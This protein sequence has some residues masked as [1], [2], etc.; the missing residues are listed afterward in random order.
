M[1]NISR[2]HWLILL[3]FVTCG[4]FTA[5]NAAHVIG[6]LWNGSQA[7]AAHFPVR[8]A[9]R[10]FGASPYWLWQVL[11]IDGVPFTRGEQIDDAIKGRRPGDEIP[12]MLKDPK[13]EV[14]KV[15]IPVVPAIRPH[16]RT[17]DIV[18]L[19]AVSLFLNVFCFALAFVVVGIR[20]RDPLA[21]LLLAVLLSFA[22]TARE[23]GWD[24][25]FPT[26]ALIWSICVR[27][28]WPVWMMLFGLYFP[29]R[30]VLD[31]WLPWL[32][33]VL[34]VLVI[35]SS[36]LMW[37][38]VI[39]WRLNIDASLPLRRYYGFSSTATLVSGMLAISVFFAGLGFSTG[40][41][42][43]RDARRRLGFIW[44]GATVSL[45]PIF[46]LALYSLASGHDMFMG[47]PQWTIFAALLTLPFFP[48]TLA[49]VIVVQRAMNLRM[50]I[51]LGLQYALAQGGVRILQMVV[52]S[53]LI[54]LIVDGVH[55]NMQVV[56]QLRI[57]GIGLLAI[58]VQARLTRKASDWIDRKF[59]REA[60]SADRIL[61]EL[62]EEARMFTESRPLIETVTERVAQTL[63]IP[64]AAVLLRDGD[65]YCLA[66]TADGFDPA[67]RC[68]PL[69]ARA[70]EQIRKERKPALV[71]FDDKSSWVNLIEPEEKRRLQALDAQVLVALSGREDL[72]GVMVLGPKQSEEPYSRHD[73]RLL[74]SVGAQT[75]LALEN[76]ELLAKLTAEAAQRERISRELEI[77]REVQDRL[78]PQDY[79]PV[80]S[81]EYCG[82]CRPALGIGGDYY[83]FIHLKSGKL[84]IAIGDVSGKGVS[85]ALLMSNLHASLRGQTMAQVADLATLMSN[86]NVLIYEASTSNRYATFFYSEYDPHTR[87]L[88][89]VNAGHNAPMLVRGG[90][91]IRLD[92]GGPVVGLLKQARYEQAS[93]Q[94]QPGDILVGYTDGISEAMTAADEEWGEERM[95]SAIRACREQKPRDMIGFMLRE[96]D[97][98]TAGAPQYDDMTL[99]ILKVK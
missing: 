9:T 10:E 63:H 6:I 3:L 99:S 86:I 58:G 32:K 41:A 4:Y 85:A 19:V 11:A 66:K 26:A 79:P 45:T 90:E 78:F 2:R 91:C 40:A 70:I 89:Y 25:P 98:F 42:K 35:A 60:Y 39:T 44:A 65:N 64:R 36:A 56:H 74:Q 5:G 49:Y 28:L 18:I 51:R 73:L 13:G 27:A 80:E 20:P 1:R 97:T 93:C 21:W 31:R 7:P 24:W 14:K 30:S 84:G 46:L 38:T 57:I 47:V 12:V 55:K 16:R 68:L 23:T 17:I 81:V 52:I 95:L 53:V 37:T 77:A 22:E 96:A 83:D 72:V 76:S 75:G 34:I 82:Y 50:V 92:A 43:D 29:Q 87:T 88:Q 48:L 33:W 94:L 15:R 8:L 62:S 54:T 71:Y 61:I 69:R 67:V 59:F